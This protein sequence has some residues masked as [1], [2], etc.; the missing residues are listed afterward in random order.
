VPT[1]DFCGEG[2]L[3]D[4]ESRCVYWTDIN[5]FLVHRYVPA[6]KTLQTWFFSEPVTGVLLTSRRDT[7]ALSVGSGAVLWKPDGDAAS[8]KIFDLP[9]WPRVRCNDA[10]VDPGGVL[11]IGSMYNNVDAS[12]KPSKEGDGEGILYRIEGSG[13]S[14]EHRRNLGISNTFVWSPDRSK[15]Y[16]GDSLANRLWSY[17]Y[18]LKSRTIA[19]ERVFFEDFERGAPDGSA[20]D[21]EG[22]IWNC[23]YGGSCIVRIAPSGKVDRIIDLPVN[24][25]TNCTFG[26]QHGNT[27]YVTSASPEPGKWERFGG[28]LFALETNV[29]GVTENKFQLDS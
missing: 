24:R 6:H 26:G 23:R 12:G 28:G 10:G 3:W 8:T 27:L 5:R 15:F 22:Y 18:D 21:T 19:G 29:T 1:G 17:D 25:P 11:W 20:I 14:S 4:Q 7:L 16:F 9:G 13:K 2:V